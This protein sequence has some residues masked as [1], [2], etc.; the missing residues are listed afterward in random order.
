MRTPRRRPVL[1]AITALAL[2]VPLAATL[3]PAAAGEI[4]ALPTVAINEVESND[5]TVADFV[6]LVNTGATPVDVSG[7]ILRDNKNDSSVAIP[8][9]SVLA[10]H[11]FLAV[12]VDVTGGFG[13]GGADSA[14]LFLAD[15]ITLVDGYSWTAHA[16]GTTYG[17]F[18][19]GTGAFA[20]TASATRGAANAAPPVRINEVESSGRDPVDWIEIV[21]TGAG[22][23]DVSGWILRDDKN[24]STVAI[25]TG[26]VLA[27]GALLAVD[28]D[29]TGGF[30][31][32]G[33][34]SARLFATDGIS[35]VDSYS[36]TGHAATTYGRVPDGIGAFVVTPAPTKG[37]SNAAIVPTPTPTPTPTPAAIRINEVESNGGTPGDWVEFYNSGTTAF[38]LGGYR[39]K[40]GD[41]AHAFL[42]V[43][44]GTSVPAGGYYVAEES[45]F[46][47][48]LGTADSARL[49]APDGVTLVDSRSWTAH[50]PTTLGVC[51]T[52]FVV[53]TSSTKGADNDC[54]APIRINE[55]ESQ[56]G[57]PGDWI[58]LRNNGV[59][60]ADASGLVIKD[61]SDKTPFTVPAGTT[62]AAG[63]YFVADLDGYFGLG[64]ADSV[65]LFAT[66]GT[67]LIDSYTWTAHATTTYGRCA[68]GT[69]EFATTASS[70]K[71]ATNDCV[72]DL[73]TAPW[74]G[75]PEVAT[76]DAKGAFAGNMSGLAYEA[77]E[78]GDVLWA[79]RNGVGALF[80]LVF[81]G[82]NWVPDTAG[83]WSAG[84]ELHYADGT[85]DVDAEGV[86]FTARGSSAGVFIASERNNGGGGS[87]LSVLRYDPAA[88]GSS[89][90]ANMEWNLNADLPVVGANLGLEGIAWVPDSYLVGGGL[91]DES[92][93]AAY[94][95][96]AYADH[97]DGLFFVALEANGTVYGYA[98]NQATGGYTRIA[99]IE[100]GFPS[101]MELEFDAE[102]QQLWALCDDTCQGRSAILDISAEGTFEVGTVYERPAAMANLNNEGFALAPRSRC[103]EGAKAAFWADDSSTDGFAIRSGSIDCAAPATPTD[104][105]TPTVPGVPATPAPLPET[106]G[107][108]PV[109]G[110]ALTEAA[111]GSV[112]VPSTAVRGTTI[113]VSVGT[114]YAGDT[115]S[116]W[117]HSAPVLLGARTVAGDG[118]VRVVVP[119]DTAL[120]AHRVAVL[121]A[122]GTLI[123]WDGITITAAGQRLASTGVDLG[124]PAGAALLLLLAGAGLVAAR[125]RRV[126]A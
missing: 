81:D 80:R 46:V 3:T 8:A 37:A 6:E 84:K 125:R 53:T 9:G 83:G 107:S 100:S 17:R 1:A 35:L 66:D 77:A 52:G 126:A 18:P 5:G 112:S 95:P 15:G 121:A 27:A 54:S 96:A 11:A 26:S 49:F 32:G 85:G 12:D 76:A 115:V 16:Q 20:L 48:G 29:V 2:T 13:L 120:G 97:G 70:T 72:G 36:W 51:G 123:G 86:A 68:D 88:A 82:T 89:L 61:N 56:D 65:R 108:T 113:T 23:V 73:V 104:P 101:V 103:V 124:A 7:W 25:P 64:G 67:T 109:P 98:L 40:D 44:A 38:D 74:P 59:A 63:G 122:D 42:V 106:G 57:A 33:A 39:F 69:G 91:V 24:S 55:I 60:S 93:G 30:G 71:G 21:N 102:N 118:T 62:I 78:T 117:L 28:V 4:A 116:V 75:S 10:A 50:S 19:D 22:A 14:R 92:T 34:D 41:D 47:W 87:R 43:P 31:L 58:E 110:D 105:G 114:Q 94:D 111:R 79:A 45:D 119:A 90:N 99:T